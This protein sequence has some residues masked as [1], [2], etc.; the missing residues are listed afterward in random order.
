MGHKCKEAVFSKTRVGMKYRHETKEQQNSHG[1]VYAHHAI[2]KEAVLKKLEFP[3][4]KNMY[5][6]PAIKYRDLARRSNSP[7]MPAHAIDAAEGGAMNRKYIGCNAVLKTVCPPLCGL[8]LQFPG[9]TD[10]GVV[11]GDGGRWSELDALRD[12]LFMLPRWREAFAVTALPSSD[13]AVSRLLEPLCL[14][15]VDALRSCVRLS[16][17]S[18]F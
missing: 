17:L 2:L 11:R 14:Y 18:S 15:L 12:W 6:N 16:S 13:V 1:N 7:E 10:V 9:N 8:S 4:A 5:R 3:K